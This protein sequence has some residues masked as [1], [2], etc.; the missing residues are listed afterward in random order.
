MKCY[1]MFCGAHLM[2]N[3][4]TLFKIYHIH[5]LSSIL[6][7]YNYGIFLINECFSCVNWQLEQQD[8][9]HIAHVPQ[10]RTDG[11]STH[12]SNV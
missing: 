4:M 10:R 9:G 8:D 6:T 12:P 11:N 7:Y 1:I 5:T 2:K 3:T